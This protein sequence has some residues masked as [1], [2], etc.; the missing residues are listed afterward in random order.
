MKLILKLLINAALVVLLAKLL[1]GVSVDS[2]GTAVIVAIVIALLNLS[3]KPLLIILT[4]PVTIL[5][6]GLFLL[7][8]NGI[9]IWMAHKLVDGFDI[10]SFW[11]GVLFSILL[12]VLQSIVHS[13]L[14][15]DKKPA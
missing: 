5:T 8:I 1:S 9:V 6:L 12:T 11:M 7:I 15:E 10:S 3:V 4:L 14:K 13:I 2:Y